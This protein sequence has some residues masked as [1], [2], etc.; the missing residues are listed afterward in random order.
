MEPLDPARNSEGSGFSRRRLSSILKVPRKSSRSLDQEQQENVIECAKSVEK[1]NSRR[2][3]F[4][5]ANDVLLFARDAKN[6]S[7][8]RSP[9]QEL[10]TA[11]GA[12]TTQ[13]RAQVGVTDDG[14]HQ[15]IGMETLLNAPLHASQQ[16]D[17]A[18]E[19]DFGEKTVMFSSEDAVMDMTQSHTINIGSEIPEDIPLDNYE[20]LPALGEKR[21][22]GDKSTTLSLSTGRNVGGSAPLSCLDPAFEN[23]LASLSKPGVQS[24][25]AVNI[26][27]TL[28]AGPSSEET[29]GSAAQ[30]KTQRA[31]LDKENQVP[32]FV[33]ALREKSLNNTRKIRES[34]CKSA[35]CPEDDVSMDMT[36]VQTGRILGVCGDV[37]DDDNPFQCLFPTQDMYAHSQMKLQQSSITS[38]LTD[39]KDKRSLIKPPVPVPHQRHKVSPDANN[40]CKDK[41]IVFA[42]DADSMDMTGCHTVNIACGTLILQQ[43][44]G[45][46]KENWLLNTTQNVREPF[47][48]ATMCPDGLNMDTTGA[49]TNQVLDDPFQFLF[50]SQDMYAHCE[51]LKKADTTLGQRISEALKSSNHKGMEASSLKGLKDQNKPDTENSCS[52]KTVRFSADDACMDVTGSPTINITQLQLQSDQKFGFLPAKEKTLTFTPSSTMDENHGLTV[53]TARNL[54]PDSFNPG[55]KQDSETCGLPRN[56]SLSVHNLDPGFSL[57][58]SS[59]IK[60]MITS[61]GDPSCPEDISMDMTEAQTGYILVGDV[62]TDRVDAQTGQGADDC[63]RDP[64]PTQGIYSQCGNL[65][66]TDWQ[67][68]EATGSSSCK[69]TFPKPSGN[70]KVQAHQVKL[71]VVDDCKEKTVRFTADDALM[72]VT[73]S[74][75]VSIISDLELQSHPNAGLLPAIGDKTVRFSID[76]AAIDVTRSHTVNI[77]SDLRLESHQNADFLQANGEKT[78]RFSTDDAV[79]DM[80]QSHTVN[81]ATDLSMQSHQNVDLLLA[82]GEK[83]VRF[84][85]NDAAMEV[86]QSHT[87]NIISDLQMQPHQEADPLLATR[88]KTVRFSIDD[89]SMDVTRSHTVNI[90]TD[91]NMQTDH[92]LPLNG[93][94]TVRFGTDDAAMDVT[95]SHTVNI[96]TDFDMRLHQNADFPPTSEEKTVRIA[97]NDGAMDMMECLT[98]NIPSVSA[99][100]SVLPVEKIPPFQENQDFSNKA[101]DLRG[102]TSSAHDLNQEFKNLSQACS[103]WVDIKPQDND[104]PSPQKATDS[105]DLMVHPKTQ[106]PAVNT[107]NEAPVLVSCFKEQPVNT[108]MTDR[109][110]ISASMDMTEPQ[111]GC[112]L[113]QTCTDDPLQCLSD[114]NSEHLRQTGSTS[115]RSDDLGLSN[116][117][118]LENINVTESLHSTKREITEEP[119]P[120]T[121]TSPTSQDVEI[122]SDSAADQDVD[123]Q[124]FR[125][126]SLADLQSKVRRLS[127]MINA[128][129]SAVVMDSC[130]APLHLLEQDLEKC[131]KDKT[132]SF[133]VAEPEP[134]M[135]MVNTE[136]NTEARSLTEA[137]HPCGAITTTPFSSKTKQ[138]M[139]RISVG[140]F[141]PKLP[142]KSKPDD[143]KNAKSAEKHTR[144]VTVSVANGLKNFNDDLSDIYD[145]ELGSY[146]DMSETVDTRSPQKSPEV[147]VVKPL[148]DSVFEEDVFNPV[149]GQKRLLPKDKT[150]MKDQKRMKPSCD[151]VEMSYVVECDSNMTTAPLTAQTA[152]CSSNHTASIKCNTASESTFKHNLFESQLEDNATDVQK[153]LEDGTITVLELFRLFSIDFVIHNPRQSVLPG[154]LLS[155]TETTPMDLL[156]DKHISRPKQMVYEMDVFN[157][158]EKVEGLKVR[159]RDLDKPLNTVNRRLWEDMRYA[160]EKERKSFG[161]KLKERNNFFRKTSKVQSHEMKEVLYSNLVQANLEEQQKL[162][163][164]I[165]EADEMIKT[166]DDCIGKLET[167]LDAI[168]EKGFQD[169]AGLKSLQEEMKQ[170]T[171]RTAE[172]ERQISELEMQK[173]HNSSKVKR[174]Q[175]ETR[176]L[177]SHMGI[178]NT[179]NEWKLREMRDNFKVYTF[180]H[181][182]MHLQLVFE[183]SNGSEA[184]SEQKITHI[185][186]KLEL[187]D[188]KSQCHA[189]LVHKLVSQY[190]EGESSWV[191]KYPTSRHVPK[192]L[193]DVSLVVSHCRLLGEELRLLKLWGGLRLDI[194]NISCTDTKVHVVFSSLKKCSK[195]EVVFAVCL[196]NHLY[197]LQ[198]ESFKNI[199]GSTT[200]QQIEET[201]A[202]FSP[203]KNL[204]TKT[205]KRIHEVLLC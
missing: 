41:T 136:D 144:T 190:I 151:T 120:I 52:E 147:N 187:D 179:I 203:A 42:A 69:E 14:S 181:E 81:I 105:K 71:D 180:L 134:A 43:K 74:H 150:N 165:Q 19:D 173:K 200:I 197:V 16:R 139:S 111:T 10:I 166:L 37:D 94:K 152:D 178:L 70:T 49:Q 182:T 85:M 65:R 54:V 137:E 7:P 98:V 62:G 60:N 103:P 56:T 129:P 8:V 172:D 108:T 140:G 73:R 12:A 175:A 188:E 155:D 1:R 9:L 27:L 156:K 46:D 164:R 184:D 15:I 90:A 198:V 130:T 167:E 112:I 66:K 91:L 79:M 110:E 6:A 53:N 193:H 31:D 26:R 119:G 64:V 204:L 44:S 135:G 100:D 80:T 3:S 192:L 185:T 141:K 146:E 25:N 5:P 124:K 191:E 18:T 171:E 86:T 68:S 118:D 33:S 186:F 128:A 199:V 38:G 4:A 78:V 189:R 153:K 58:D 95:R 131:P 168:E 63:V 28:P 51:S 157:L 102:K 55:K 194:L 29:N 107:E 17:K 61:N 205:V 93:E 24:T 177:E 47:K 201:V 159:M 87:V 174:L 67:R 59:S 88:D 11:T 142:Q 163:G 162:R 149:Q 115:Q 160:S 84:T 116:P 154:R 125:R 92:S 20:I 123:S 77:I 170:V 143:S 104:T 22:I 101:F 109:P 13:N 89:A 99:S 57:T 121:T 76:D 169:K 75:T 36:E 127:C 50:P 122:H 183:K 35:L 132:I 196:I 176:N 39:P 114:P 72:D 195:F 82:N 161:T 96:A 133:A 113:G 145:E 158:T 21:F 34:S 48:G 117:D 23:F 97:A 138:L 148:E 32:V 126:M 30:I 45:A 83:T 202:S 2:V 106:N 40:E